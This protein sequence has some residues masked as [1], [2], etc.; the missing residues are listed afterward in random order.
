MRLATIGNVDF[1][2]LCVYLKFLLVS[3]KLL[4]QVLDEKE[5]FILVYT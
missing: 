2:F 5:V 4:K 3:T 1:I